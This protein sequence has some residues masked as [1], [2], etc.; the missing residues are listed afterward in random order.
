M[1]CYIQDSYHYSSSF[2]NRS[3][4][5]SQIIRLARTLAATHSLMS[6]LDQL[7]I[8]LHVAKGLNTWQ[9][10]AWANKFQF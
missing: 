3:K 1:L 5:E 7:R 10:L 9:I 4:R 6:D 8:R 2:L